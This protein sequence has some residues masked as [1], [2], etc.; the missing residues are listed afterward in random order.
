[1]TKH[2][3]ERCKTHVIDCANAAR[4]EL[5]LLPTWLNGAHMSIHQGSGSWNTLDPL[6]Y[7]K[8]AHGFFL[9]SWN[10]WGCSA[11]YTQQTHATL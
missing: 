5:S 4:Q 7:S 9:H 1:V 11:V 10:I 8:K 6:S 2:V 3:S